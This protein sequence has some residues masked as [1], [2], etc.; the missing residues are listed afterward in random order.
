MFDLL[1]LLGSGAM[2]LPQARR[3]SRPA[4]Q[5]SILAVSSGASEAQ[6]YQEEQHTHSESK[7]LDGFS[8][9][10][11]AMPASLHVFFPKSDLQ[12]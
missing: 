7:S 3:T 8:A 11:D 9:D 6:L 12:Q 5:C 10:E 1:Y 4:L 2:L